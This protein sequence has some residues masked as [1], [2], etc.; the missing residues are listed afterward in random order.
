MMMRSRG[1]GVPCRQ[2]AQ[3]M[4]SDRFKI[5]CS[6]LMISGTCMGTTFVLCPKQMTN[7]GSPQKTTS[8]Q[9]LPLKPPLPL[10]SFGGVRDRFPIAVALV[11]AVAAAT[12][13]RHALSSRSRK[14][15]IPHGTNFRG[16]RGVVA[17]RAAEASG[18]G[19]AGLT[20]RW[21]CVK[22]DGDVDEYWKACGLPWL[23][24]KGLQLM[25]WGAT[26]K[27]QNIR[28]FTQTGDDIEMKYSFKGMGLGG[29][30]FTET[31]RVGGGVQEITR[32]GGAKMF[33]D[34]TW[35]SGNILQVTNM[36]PEKQTAGWTKSVLMGKKEEETDG[37]AP[38][39]DVSASG[40]VVDVHKFYM[41]GEDTLVLE[42]DA[43]QSGGPVV[44]FFL[45]RLE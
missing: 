37:V 19:G 1:R 45:K 29:L 28:E 33:V 27:N 35:D 31:Y 4:H 11:G 15:A 7:N 5:V 30:G 9:P 10:F 40:S 23:A 18:F 42:A 38:D 26:E 32:M 34:P 39:S 2:D 8:A 43:S 24:R 36:A 3:L 25:D 6:V 14:A 21:G 41:E 17:V 13:S 22:I 12:L 20:G 44:K 16:P